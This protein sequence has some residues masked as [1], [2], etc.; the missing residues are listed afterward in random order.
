MGDLCVSH[1]RNDLGDGVS[2]QLDGVGGNMRQAERSYVSEPLDLV[3]DGIGVWK[4][5]AVIHTWGSGLSDHPVDLRLNLFCV[6]R[7]D[8]KC[9]NTCV[10]FKMLSKCIVIF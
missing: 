4:V 7:E 9:Q 6:S 3:D 2:L 10:A 8:M 1:Q 5:H